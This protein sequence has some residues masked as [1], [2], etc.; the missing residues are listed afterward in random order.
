MQQS[1]PLHVDQD[2]F[3][4]ELKA[5]IYSH[6]KIPPNFQELY[7]N[8]YNKWEK[9]VDDC[10]LGVYNIVQDQRIILKTPHYKAAA[11]KVS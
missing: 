1:L 7:F 3:V 8:Q 9:M 2:I 11:E 10:N 6:I 5:I 4:S